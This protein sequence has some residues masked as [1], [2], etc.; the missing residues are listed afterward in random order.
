VIRV[1]R[2]L[3]V[4]ALI[5]L[6]G[7]NQAATGLPPGGPASPATAP[8]PAAT[9]PAPAATPGRAVA[10][11]GPKQA[12]RS[13]VTPADRLAGVRSNSVRWKSGGRLRTVPGSSKAPGRGRVYQV[14]VQVESGL[15]IDRTAFATFVLA[16]LNDQRSWT[17]HGRRRFARTD[18]P[19][20]I[21]VVL[22][23]P[24][25]SAAICAPLRTYGKLSCR[26]GSRAVLTLYRWI[27]AIGEYSGDRTGYRHYV[28]N[29]E[30]GHVLGHG[31]QYCAG[32]GKLAPLMMQQT[33]GLKG[34]RPNPWPHP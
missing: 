18:G 7:C 3:L 5:G 16:T 21:T 4:V 33:K 30:V 24:Q 11:A 19:A 14:R 1:V 32:R 13:P 29:H 22:A 6:V 10:T 31:H 23:S 27:K 28:V 12:E 25:T 2:L 17:E 34:C 9:S 26:T 20:D 8:V 15:D